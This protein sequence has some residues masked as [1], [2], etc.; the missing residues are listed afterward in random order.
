[1]EESIGKCTCL[2]A[3]PKLRLLTAIIKEIERRKELAE[4]FPEK[5][6]VGLEEVKKFTEIKDEI[7]KLPYC[8]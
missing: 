5:K 4:M 1:M 7:E 6:L 3:G 8:R 2:Y